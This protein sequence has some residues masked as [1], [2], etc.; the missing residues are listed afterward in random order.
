MADLEW[1]LIYWHYL[2]GRGDFIRLLFEEAGVPY[3]DVCRRE[4]KSTAVLRH[5]KVSDPEAQKLFQED[6]S[7]YPV[8]APPIIVRGDFIM[9]ST[10]AILVYLGKKFGLYPSGG[11]EEEAHALQI[12]NLVT[13]FV[14]EGYDCFHPKSKLVPYEPQ[15]EE[16]EPFIKTFVAERLSKCVLVCRTMWF[17]THSTV[18]YT[19]FWRL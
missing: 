9:N 5:F 12:N 16:A 6:A 3:D 11:D 18:H 17:I 2:P 10:P 8:S 19:G 13:D 15:K 7:S 14:A 4:G 1:K